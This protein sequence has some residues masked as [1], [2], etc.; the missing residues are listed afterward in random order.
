MTTITATPDSVT[1][2]NQIAVNYT[3]P[4]SRVLRNDAN[5]IAEVR[6]LAGQL[7]TGASG[8]LIL[9]DYEA[10]AGV[11]TYTAYVDEYEVRT[12]YQT[13]PSPAS[14][15]GFVSS[16]GTGTWSYMTDESQT[17]ARFTK[18]ATS[19][20]TALY[21]SNVIAVP[22]VGTIVSLRFN[23]RSSVAATLTVRD[24]S[25]AI[26]TAVYDLPPNVWTGILVEG[27]ATT[28]AS[29]RPAFVVSGMAAN[30]TWD[31][32]RILWDQAPSVPYWFNGYTTDEDNV[33]YS[34]S[35]TAHASTSTRTEHITQVAASTTLV[36]GKPWLMVPVMP[37]YSLQT[38]AITGYGSNR[39]SLS[40]VHNVIGR[41]DP[42]VSFGPLGTRTGSLEVFCESLDAAR[43]LESIFTRGE[44]VMLKQNLPGMDMYFLGS[45]TGVR[46]YSV[47]GE[48]LTRWALTVAYTEIKRPL[49]SLAGALGWDFNALAAAYASFDVVSSTFATFDDLTIRNE[50]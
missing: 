35:G 23:V 7:P 4:V 32:K 1:S 14:T 13:N 31:I 38:E 44:T 39:Q 37:N 10:S 48:G 46:P 12:N 45:A 27:Y 29:F 30:S 19:A 40:T 49:G 50:Q 5:G 22:A 17:Y 36:L 28:L 25:T 6:T 20:T 43:D 3:S 34:W 9:S 15:T 24:G 41:A 16:G 11:N 21:M 26:T 2:S 8:T 18:D 42:L 47:Q 33:D